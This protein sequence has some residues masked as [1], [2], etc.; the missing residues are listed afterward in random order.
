MGLA[1]NVGYPPYPSFLSADPYY[2]WKLG[3][4][5]KITEL[6]LNVFG[7]SLFYKLFGR[8]FD[9]IF[10]A[11]LTILVSALIA[12][13]KGVGKKPVIILFLALVNPI[14]FSQIF[15]VNKEIY[16]ICVSLL[17]VASHRLDSRILE[18]AA[19]ILLIFTKIEFGALVLFWLILKRFKLQFQYVVIV[20]ILAGIS[21]FYNRLPGMADKLGVLQANQ[22]HNS[23]GLT[24]LL[25]DWAYNHYLFFMVVV[26]RTILNIFSGFL[27]CVRG[28]GFTMA[29]LPGVISSFVMSLLFLL[30][31]LKM[32]RNRSR[33]EPIFILLWLILTATVPF[34]LHRYLLPI[35][36]F[37]VSLCLADNSK[38]VTNA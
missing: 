27:D 25:Q 10:L 14:I 7:P 22:G 16:M 18:I 30:A 34:A 31:T 36:P 19:I 33:I 3:E 35:Y 32:I 8:Q 21:L 15:F 4:L 6:P 1:L 2:Y 28:E 24:V 11:N 37:L 38:V 9:I 13:A 26:P 17:L 5:F 12:F 29:S 23:L 20:A